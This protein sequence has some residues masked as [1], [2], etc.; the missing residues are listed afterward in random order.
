MTVPPFQG[1]EHV[2]DRTTMKV[3]ILRGLPVTGSRV[4]GCV[5]DA[6]AGESSLRDLIWCCWDRVHEKANNMMSYGMRLP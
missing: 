4:G 5:G 3:G 2:T 1:F 6:L